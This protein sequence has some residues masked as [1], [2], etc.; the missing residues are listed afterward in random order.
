MEAAREALAEELD[1]Q[2]LLS[3][4]ITA[5]LGAV[6][7]EE[8]FVELQALE[9]EMVGEE[10]TKAPTTTTTTTTTTAALVESMPDISKIKLSDATTATATTSSAATNMHKT[11]LPS[12]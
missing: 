1:E 6:D 8:L 4:G 2:Q 9:K 7:D 11:A 3:E 5:P 10:G 12:K